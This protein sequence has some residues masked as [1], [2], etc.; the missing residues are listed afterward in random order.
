MAA[1]LPAEL[2]RAYRGKRFLDI[3]AASLGLLVLSPLLLV[4]GLLIRLQDGGAALYRQVRV[5]RGGREFHILKF[6]TMVPDADRQG[7]ALTLHHDARIT[8]VGRW[9]RRLK[10]DELPQLVNV[11]RGEM[12]LVGPRPEVPKYV[13]VYSAA[14]R[15]VLACR[16]GLTDPTSLV[17]WNEAELLARSSEPERLYVETLLPQKIDAALA[18]ARRASLASDLIVLVATVTGAP[19]LLR[20]CGLEARG[21]DLGY[22]APGST[23]R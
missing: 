13:A 5:G 16:P 3:V 17:L 11:L 12:S 6:R 10:L 9:L 20:Y 1:T 4:I 22:L 2:P 19:G 21:F 8:P 15:A 23:A 7:G 18:Y 14:Q